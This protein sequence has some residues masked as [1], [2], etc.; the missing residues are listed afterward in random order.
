MKNIQL[1]ADTKFHSDAPFTNVDVVFSSNHQLEQLIE[2]LQAL[3]N[4]ENIELVELADD[5]STGDE[6]LE[7]A[8]YFHKPGFKRDET[9]ES[10]LKSAAN[11]IMR[12]QNG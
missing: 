2:A 8:V 11:L 9:D 3:L 12:Y 5:A 6:G 7:A 10:C 1:S 4:D